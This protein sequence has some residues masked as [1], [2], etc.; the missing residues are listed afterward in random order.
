MSSVLKRPHDQ[1][2]ASVFVPPLVKRSKLDSS[3]A[4]LS[5]FSCEEMARRD[6]IIMHS[7]SSDDRKIFLN[8][9]QWQRVSLCFLD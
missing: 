8:Q 5:T 2:G 7:I 3:D 4:E 1:S 6:L 9:L